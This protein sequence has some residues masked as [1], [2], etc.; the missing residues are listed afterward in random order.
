MRLRGLGRSPRQEDFRETL[1]SP[2]GPG[3]VIT[4][5]GF[6]SLLVADGTDFETAVIACFVVVLP[7]GMAWYGPTVGANRV[8]RGRHSAESK[9]VAPVFIPGN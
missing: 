3:L 2:A 8:R 9:A 5:I 7:V 1:R 4:L 6:T